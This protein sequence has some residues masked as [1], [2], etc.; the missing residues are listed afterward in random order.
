MLKGIA[1][2]LV[3]IS[4]SYCTKIKGTDIGAELI[5]AVDNVYTFDTSFEIQ[6]TNYLVPDSAL[7]RLGRDAS[8]N[9][10]DYI[11]GYISNNFQFGKTKASIYVEFKPI[12]YPLTYENVSDSLYFDSAFLC[13]R[14]TNTFGD[15]NALQ[16]ISVY[17]IN[18][19]LKGDSAY[20]TNKTVSYAEKL[21]SSTFAPSSLNDSLFLLGQRINNQLRIRINDQFASKFLSFD[22][23]KSSP[24]NNDS[25]FRDYLKGF[26]V[27]P[28]V[29]GT[30]N[31]LMSIN[32]S[33]TASYFRIY[34]R[35]MKNGKLDT[36][37]K[38]LKLNRALP[39]AAVNLIQRDYSGSE[40]ERHLSKKPKGDSLVFIQATPGSY[41]MLNI[42]GID[43]FKKSKGNVM[44]HLAE[45]QFQEVQ[46]PGRQPGLFYAPFYLYGEI[47]DTASK[48]VYPFLSDAFINGSF[49]DQS[50]GGL[51]TYKTDNTIQQGAKYKMNIT[52]YVQGIITKNFP[53]MPIKLSAPYSV[54][55]EQLYITF[56][57]NNLCTGNVVLGGGN[58]STNKMKLRLVYS[59]L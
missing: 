48:A 38:N 36:T 25:T 34:Y 12:V 37:F 8:G 19:L 28:E 47:Y 31:A 11:L 29:N 16:T 57:L 43:D 13:L 6:G 24:L 2:F 54:R 18:E 26:A 33:D 5:P 17:R 22:T 32:V 35:V 27:V 52:R 40:I 39:S 55:Y 23:S 50:F 58:N 45:L 3:I 51:R 10:G 41:A 46:T 30:A 53:N 4:F 49:D 15:T 44:V 20:Q 14:Y 42:P 7:P 9:T 56:A 1:G 59:K 21:G